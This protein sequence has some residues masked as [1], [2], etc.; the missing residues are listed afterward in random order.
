MKDTLE[1]LFHDRIEISIKRGKSGLP[2]Y[3]TS[4]R[5]FYDVRIM[6]ILFS[7][8]ELKDIVQTD[9]RKLK[10]GLAQYEKTFGGNVAYCISNLT[11]RKR[12]ALI[13]DEIP[14][15]AP[16]GQVFLPFM[17]IALKNAFPKDRIKAEKMSPL[18]QLL[19]LHLLYSGKE[20]TKAQLADTLHVTRAAITKVTERLSAKNLISEKKHGKEIHVSLSGKPDHCFN[21]AKQW[22]IDPISRVVYCADKTACERFPKSGE[23]ALSE[24][25]MLSNPRNDQR[26]CYEKD[27]MLSSLTLLDDDKWANNG[28]LVRLELWKYDPGLLCTSN[29]VDV[30]SMFLTLEDAFDERVQG[31]L[32][33]VMEA[34]KWQ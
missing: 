6:G 12:E 26:A 19:F 34:H 29:R 14:F 30:I 5:L 17:G 13:R 2:M 24:I 20:Y 11:A 9:I 10:N 25:S 18:E 7:V 15:I 32:Q 22:M 8:V 28:D 33:N 21:T 16:P 1:R 23:S 27:E 4:G 3:L 31:E